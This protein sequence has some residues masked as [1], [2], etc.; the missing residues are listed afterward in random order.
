MIYDLPPYELVL[1]LLLSVLSFWFSRSS[2]VLRAFKLLS[3][4]FF[5]LALPSALTLVLG[6]VVFPLS[7]I[8]L[9]SGALLIAL[10]IVL[11]SVRSLKEL[12][13]A[14]FYDTLT[15]AF[16]R[17]F[18]IEYISEEIRKSRRFKNEFAILLVD[19]NDFKKVND[20]YGHDAGDEVLREVVRKLRKVLRNYDMIARWG[21]D[22]F[23]IFLPIEHRADILE[24]AN[25][26]ATD[27]YLDFQGVRITLSVGY[28]C[29]PQDGESIGKLIESADERMY[30]SKK[31]YKEARRN[32]LDN[33]SEEKV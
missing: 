10:S 24:V 29:F 16:N 14:A 20:T 22:E 2:K 9:I 7:Q 5:L 17:R 33:K 6:K 31:H 28:A 23:L 4:G 12:E 1:F 13:E 19:L 21:G 25:R 26:L 30:I 8:L 18:I 15:G 3:L 27:F 11:L 32:A